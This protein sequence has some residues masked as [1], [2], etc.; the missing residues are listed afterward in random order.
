MFWKQV[1]R[2][3]LLS[4]KIQVLWGHGQ[5]NWVNLKKKITVMYKSENIYLE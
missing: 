2:D 3:P 4:G 1:N 5:Y